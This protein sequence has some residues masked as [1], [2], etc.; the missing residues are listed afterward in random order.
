MP[1]PAPNPIR[2]TRAS[3]ADKHLGLIDAPKKKRTPT[4]KRADDQRVTDSRVAKEAAVE[5]VIQQVGELENEMA[6]DQVAAIAPAK[7][8]RPKP[9][10]YV[11][12]NKGEYTPLYTGMSYLPNPCTPGA[13][14]PKD[15]A[16]QEEPDEDPMDVDEL[17]TQH[18]SREKAAS[19]RL[20]E[21]VDKARELKGKS[22]S[23]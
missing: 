21:C 13:S 10:Q 17:T 20:R 23:L 18:L 22:S 15:V 14:V 1:T 16:D 11:K 3:N 7:P 6:N 12:G 2:R 8:M 9:R 19:Q 5:R 4:E